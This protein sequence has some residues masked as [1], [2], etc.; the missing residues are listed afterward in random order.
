MIAVL[1]TL[2]TD[3]TFAA[4]DDGGPMWLL[5]LGPAGAGGLYYVLYS[6][7]RNTQKSHSFERET[8]VDAQPVTGDDVKVDTVT[9]T[10]KRSIDGDNRT[11]LRRRV[12][13]F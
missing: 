13:R 8:R 11:D 9:G 2:L 10:K 5:A 1:T 4:S 3:A 12:Q 7:Y 6:Y